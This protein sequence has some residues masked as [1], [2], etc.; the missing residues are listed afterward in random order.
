M[1]DLGCSVYSL[2]FFLENPYN[3]IRKKHAC[4]YL[5]TA[6]TLFAMQSYKSLSLI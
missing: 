4:N 5:N 3:Y 6:K 2:E 1:T